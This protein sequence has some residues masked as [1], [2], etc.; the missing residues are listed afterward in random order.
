M[1]T[2]GRPVAVEPQ[3]GCVPET[4]GLCLSPECSTESPGMDPNP[5]RKGSRD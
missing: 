2:W 5:K 1:W 4:R 3:E